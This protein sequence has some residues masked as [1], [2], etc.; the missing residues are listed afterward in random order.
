M[1]PPAASCRARST[2]R[3]E[4]GVRPATAAEFTIP[5]AWVVSDGAGINRYP[6]DRRHGRRRTR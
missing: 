3:E 1:T 5:E 6:A 2:A 4:S